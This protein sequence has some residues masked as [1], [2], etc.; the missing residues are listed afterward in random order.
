MSRGYDRKDLNVGPIHA[1]RL[2]TETAIKK[3]IDES[4]HLV[5]DTYNWTRGVKPY[6][7][8]KRLKS[9]LDVIWLER[10][11][12]STYQVIFE[13]LLAVH[14]RN[15]L[16]NS[17]RYKSPRIAQP[18]KAYFQMKKSSM[19]N[20]WKVFAMKKC[21]LNPFATGC[22]VFVCRAHAPYVERLKWK[23]SFQLNLI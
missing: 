13:S 1:T 17:W 18:T 19:I 23:I 5:E 7:I 2:K 8:N 16:K 4:K 12:S 15:C 14:P 21:R 9:L 20:R 10:K 6:L 22:C 11:S 3:T